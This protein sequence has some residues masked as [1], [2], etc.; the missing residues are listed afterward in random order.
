MFIFTFCITWP[1]VYWS[2]E[3]TNHTILN[4][5]P[6]F[7]ILNLSSAFYHPHFIIRIL[8][9]AFYHP[10]FIIHILSSSFYHPH[11]SSAFCHTHFTIHIFLPPDPFSFLFFDYFGKRGVS[12]LLLEKFF[13]DKTDSVTDRKQATYGS[14]YLTWNWWLIKGYLTPH[15]A[16][17]SNFFAC[18]FL[19]NRKQFSRIWESVTLIWH[20]LPYL[21]KRDPYLEHVR[22][23]LGRIKFRANLHVLYGPMKSRIFDASWKS[24]DK[25]RILDSFDRGNEA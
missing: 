13:I 10:H 24:R 18:G 5:Y 21:G 16:F 17:F 1:D 7:S 11:F 22:S 25:N 12:W 8:S 6:H 19:L 14:I 4:I 3:P 15:S 23:I 2:L 20:N 9:S